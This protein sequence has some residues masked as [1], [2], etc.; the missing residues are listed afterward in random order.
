[1]STIYSGDPVGITIEASSKAILDFDLDTFEGEQFDYKR[2]VIRVQRIDGNIEIETVRSMEALK[3]GEPNA[4]R[5][6]MV[7]PSEM[8]KQVHIN[9]EN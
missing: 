7:I 6:V 3:R 9:K 2:N 1:M 5:G 8:V 4:G